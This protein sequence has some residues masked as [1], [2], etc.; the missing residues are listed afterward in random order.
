MKPVHRY[1]RD[2]G[3]SL[4][5]PVRVVQALSYD[6]GV[7]NSVVE[8]VHVDKKSKLFKQIDDVSKN[9]KLSSLN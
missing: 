8:L 3:T 7:G 9:V 5:K 4:T 1:V 6:G 2:T